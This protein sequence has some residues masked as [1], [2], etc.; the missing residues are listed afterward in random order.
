MIKKLR[1]KFVCVVMLI[2]TVMLSVILGMV[3][4]FTGAI[5]EMQSVNMM[6]QMGAAPFQPGA[7]GKE[8]GPIPMAFFTVQLDQNGTIMNATGEFYDLSDKAKLQQLVDLAMEQREETGELKDYALRFFKTNSVRGQRL[9]FS[10]I[11]NE[12]ITVRNMLYGCIVIGT[13]AFFVFLAITAVLSQWVVRPV[14]KAWDQ[15]R[16]FVA[17]AS[18]ELKTPLAV[19]MANA[20]LLQN[21]PTVENNMKFTPNILS[22]SYQMR[23]LVENMLEMARV[24]DG[25]EKLQFTPLELSQLVSDA[26]LSFQLLYEEKNMLL[27]SNVSE[28]ISVSGSEQHL[29]QVMD[30]LLDN[31][32]KYSAPN[33]TVTVELTG[34][35][36]HC[37]LKVTSP[38]EQLSKE[39]LKNIFK[40]FYRADKARTMNGSYGL[41][42]SIAESIVQAHKGKI[43][44]E[45]RDGQNS[46]HIQLPIKNESSPGRKGGGS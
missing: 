1:I 16:Q 41:G 21:E 28:G 40:R 6:R 11:S 34:N 18:H 13:V 38:G 7:P 22:T 42:L 24:D 35:G 17:D 46:F 23:S 15:Q 20:E 4:H 31:A 37:L 26:V 30:V 27:H 12:K 5:M 3:V 14:E 43:W 9:V 25:K 32:L 10:D 39:D 29:Y 33:A 19:I 36:R 8:N 44:A 2:I 45:S